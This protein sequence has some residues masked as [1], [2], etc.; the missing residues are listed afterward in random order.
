MV[1]AKEVKMMLLKMGLDNARY[2]ISS[3]KQEG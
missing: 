2:G 1:K 3:S